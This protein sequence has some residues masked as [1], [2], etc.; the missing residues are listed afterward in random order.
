[1][2]R[3]GHALGSS[4]EVAKE[5]PYMSVSM[6]LQEL[7]QRKR[8]NQPVWEMILEIMKDLPE[9]DIEG[10]PSDGS[11][12]HDHYIYGTPKRQS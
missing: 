2:L 1:V 4:N 9:E 11:D 12:Q 8:K 3:G 10:L 7:T 6:T 5:N